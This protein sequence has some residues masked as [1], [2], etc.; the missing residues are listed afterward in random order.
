MDAFEQAKAFF[1]EGIRHY[2]AGRF[3]QAQAQFEAS[4]SLL[5]QRASTLTNLGATRIRLGRFAD[6][7]AVLEEATQRDPSD[8]QAWGHRATAL[9]ELGRIADALHCAEE[10]LRRDERLH[11]VWTARGN[12]LRETGRIEEAAECFRQALAHGGD[13]E[14]NAYF[15]AGLTGGEGPAAPPRRYVQALFD[16]YAEG[17]EQHLREV[18]DY[19]APDLLVRG[20][21]DQQFEAALDLGC[22][23]GLVGEQLR[24]RAKRIIGV[25]LSGNM[26]Q[27]A[28]ARGVYDDVAQADALD[29]LRAA[30]DTFDLVVA[31]DLFIYV[32]E[33]Q[34]LFAQV[35]RVIA[36]GG[37]FCFTVERAAASERV[38]LR[39]SLRYVH[40]RAYIESLASEIDFEIRQIAE[41]PLR[42]EQRVPIPGLFVWLAKR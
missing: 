12:L 7:L 19:R 38:A 8:A 30:N 14:L 23:T 1:L 41:Q 32:G 34:Q 27:Q 28:R 18:L 40:S 26:V 11:A 9:A 33:L 31:A 15:L 42:E 5:P 16:G 13:A 29:Y 25:D 24:G 17:F 3:E 35:H 21:S 2:E 6:A 36:T 10:A 20:L 39:P 22:G 37:M 4:L